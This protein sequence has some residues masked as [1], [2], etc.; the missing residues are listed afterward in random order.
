MV[1]WKNW[2]KPLETIDVNFPIDF[3]KNGG[4]KWVDPAQVGLVVFMRQLQTI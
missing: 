1:I 4:L 2:P 3:E